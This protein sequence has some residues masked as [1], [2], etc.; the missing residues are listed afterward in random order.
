ML[1]AINLHNRDLRV[2]A[3]DLWHQP[4]SFENQT[5]M[6]NK[7]RETM[8]DSIVESNATTTASDCDDDAPINR[9]NDDC[10]LHIFMYLPI[11]DHI[12]LERGIF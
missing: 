3:A 4:D 7:N 9:L 12:R 2:S 8:L 10:L 11:V 5:K 6:H 1:K